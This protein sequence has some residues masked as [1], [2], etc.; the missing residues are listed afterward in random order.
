MAIAGEQIRQEA[1]LVEN[2]F[3]DKQLTRVHEL[4]GAFGGNLLQAAD[5]FRAIRQEALEDFVSQKAAVDPGVGALQ[6]TGNSSVIPTEI[7][8]LDRV[9]RPR[10]SISAQ[11]GIDHARPLTPVY[12]PGRWIP[13]HHQPQGSNNTWLA[14]LSPPCRTS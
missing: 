3:N 14:Q 4:S 8:D 9:R 1:V 6:G 10:W 5:V 12:P 2:G 13:D 7:T 11:A